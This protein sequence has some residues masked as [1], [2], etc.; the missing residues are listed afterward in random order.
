MRIA[1]A[2]A[3]IL[4]LAACQREKTFDERFS[5][6]SSRLDAKAGAIE[7]ELAVSASDA[8]EVAALASEEAE[9][10]PEGP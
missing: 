5:E 8:G 7:K 9:T 6:A 3:L 4:A 1:S 10:R 2:L